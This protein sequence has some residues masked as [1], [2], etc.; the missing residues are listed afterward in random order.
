VAADTVALTF[1]GFG[2]IRLAGD[3]RGDPSAPAVLF[4]HG[5]GQTRH[6]WAGSA[7][8]VA[9]RGW[10]A[11]TVDA[12]GHGE[13]DWAPDQDYRL[14]SFAADIVAV[15]EAL[16]EPPVLVGASLGGMA[17]ILALGEL[18]PGC[19][20]G[21]VLVD[22]IPAMEPA[23]A[24]RIQTFMRANAASGFGS[25]EEVADAVAAYNPHR[26]RPADLTG[27]QKNVRLRDGR[28]YWHWDPVFIDGGADRRPNESFDPGRLEGDV[29]S[30]LDAGVPV[31][32]VRGRASD[33]VTQDAAEAFVARFPAVELVDVSGAGHMVAGDRND[34]FTDAVV[35]F[36]DRHKR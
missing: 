5:G 26:R 10:Q 17:C 34:A 20:R 30:I 21:L 13:S 16:G 25:L 9:D 22:I 24:E 35:D 15:T 32:L 23:G 11:I 7:A 29:G 19:A 28:W 6:S 31:L 27:L 3:R 4:L 36:L 12:R 33:L 2:G 18:A 1:T 14:T 8:A